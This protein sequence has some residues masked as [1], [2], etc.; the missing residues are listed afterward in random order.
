MGAPI[1]PLNYAQSEAITTTTNDS[2]LVDVK[3]SL[4]GVA[5]DYTEFD[6]E[7]CGAINTALSILCQVGVIRPA[8]L[9]PVQNDSVKWQ[10]LIPEDMRLT[11]AK[12][13]VK[14]KV[15][16]IFDPPTSGTLHGALERRCDEELWRAQMAAEFNH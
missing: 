3:D 15:K 7:I 14:D 6:S 9:R 4:G 2:I 12:Q 10:D 13:Y 1:N 11:M 16:L 5:E 8:D